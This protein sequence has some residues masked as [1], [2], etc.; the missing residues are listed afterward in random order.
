MEALLAALGKLLPLLRFLQLLQ[1]KTISQLKVTVHG[2]IEL[3]AMHV[4]CFFTLFVF[5][6]RHIAFVVN[7]TSCLKKEYALYH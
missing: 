3:D 7:N 4:T 1:P 2:G 6:S 5:C